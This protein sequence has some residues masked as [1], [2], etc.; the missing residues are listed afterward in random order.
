MCFGEDIY[1]HELEKRNRRLLVK[2]WLL[3]AGP[4]TAEDTY[5]LL[6]NLVLQK[7]PRF[8]HD[9]WKQCTNARSGLAHLSSLPVHPD[10]MLPLFTAFIG[11]LPANTPPVLDAPE[12]KFQISVSARN[13]S[14]AKFAVTIGAGFSI[15]VTLRADPV[16]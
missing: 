4:A 2:T 3:N 12:F 6:N 1:A 5:V 9:L 13:Q 10:V 15:G 14:P 7:Q 16:V 11:E 8:E